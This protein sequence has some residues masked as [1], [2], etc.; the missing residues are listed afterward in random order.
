MCVQCSL[1]STR[2]SLGNCKEST[3]GLIASFNSTY[4][5]QCV[6]VRKVQFSTEG[7][8]WVRNCFKRSRNLHHTYWKSIYPRDSAIR[9]SF[10]CHCADMRSFER[11]LFLK[12][13][14]LRQNANSQVQLWLQIMAFSSQ[15]IFNALGIFCDQRGVLTF[16]FLACFSV[17]LVTLTFDFKQIY[18]LLWLLM[19]L[20]LSA[21]DRG[22]LYND[23]A[24]LILLFCVMMTLNYFALSFDHAVHVCICDSF[25]EWSKFTVISIQLK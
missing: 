16:R 5:M 24:V 21:D 22:Y 14:L 10:V 18:L 2:S 25:N 3:D 1:A 20:T 6:T 4:L 12:W 8:S 17:T 11:L 13:Y 15:C 23:H 19:S 9:T 7:C